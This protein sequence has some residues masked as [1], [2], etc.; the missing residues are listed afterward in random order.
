[1]RLFVVSIGLTAAF[2]TNTTPADADVFDGPYFG[3]VTRVIDGDT[4]E[5]RVDIWPDISATVSVRLR[6]VDAPEIH[7][8]ECDN[9]DY[10]GQRAFEALQH[11]LP[12]GQRIRLQQVSAGSFSGRII[13]NVDRMAPQR[14]APVQSLAALRDYLIDYENGGDVPNPWCN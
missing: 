13:A 14:G 2:L 8:P 9:E 4:F 7:R 1:M 5:A 11:E 12:V 6:G 3:E 10:Q